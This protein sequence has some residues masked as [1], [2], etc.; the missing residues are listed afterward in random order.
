MT[1]GSRDA[2]TVRLARIALAHVV[3]PGS[4]ELAGI[5][6][7]AGP[8]DGLRRIL[9]GNA[10]PEL[11]EMCASRL[12]AAD[13]FDL[14]ERA[15]AVAE[16]LGARII[17]PEEDEWPRQ[18]DDLA[19]ISRDVSDPIHRDTFPPQAVWLRGPWP[20]AAVCDRSV[21]V[22]GARASTS[23]GDH[24]AAEFGYGLVQREWTV[25]SGGA[26]GIDAAAH[27]GALAAGGITVSVLACGIDR[28]YPLSH[29]SLFGRIADEGL[30]FSEWPPG[31]DPHRRRFLVRNRVIA[32]L[33]RGTVV[34]EAS[35]RSGARFTLGRARQL[36]RAQL[37]VPGPITSTM[38]EGCHEEIRE[39]EAILVASVAQVV[40]A[41]GQ[42]GVD[43]APPVR[44]EESPRD[45]LTPAQ[46]QVLDGVRPRKILTAEEI[47]A[48]VGV[49]ARQVRSALP[50]LVD[51]GFVAVQGAGYRLTRRS[52]TKAE[53]GEPRPRRAAPA[54]GGRRAVPS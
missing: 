27:R 30:L 50:E 42:I 41:V 20:L 15:V 17:T 1:D 25:V 21:A 8:V 6:A 11:A 16:R 51:L 35:A 52:D 43:L 40:E 2:H 53:T 22:V 7:Q 36:S 26:F 48:V 29:A 39:K 31:A 47:A 23:Y 33:T 5:V 54:S 45:Q 3:E 12:G 13:P 28:P 46:R 34:V 49:T 4:R 38:S 37:V 18:L 44:G 24:V 32:A 14:A 9:A 19:R 10:S